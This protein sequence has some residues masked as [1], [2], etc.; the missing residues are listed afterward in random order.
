MNERPRLRRNEVPAYLMGKFGIPVALRTLNKMATVGG[1]PAMQYSGRI[2]LY[3]VDDLDAWA[4]A[5]L[6]KPVSSTAER[7]LA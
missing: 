7:S 3:H 4:E 6:S 2:P 1:G 5:R